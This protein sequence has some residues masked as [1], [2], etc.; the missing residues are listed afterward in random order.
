MSGPVGVTAVIGSVAKRGILDLLP[1]LA[2]ITVNLG[3]F[4]LLPVPALDG[5]RAF[6]LLI[7]M[8]IRRP[9]PKKFEGAV[10]TAGLILLL[11]FIAVITVKDIIWLF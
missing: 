6:F 9:I 10:H 2:L 11:G 4:N 8:I 3:V 1:M 5:G 7:E